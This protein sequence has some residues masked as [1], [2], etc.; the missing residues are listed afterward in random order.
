MDNP[1]KARAT[2]PTPFIAMSSPPLISSSTSSSSSPSPPRQ[3]PSP[4]INAPAGFPPPQQPHPTPLQ[5]VVL[6]PCAACKI[7]RR[8]CTDNCVLA[9]YFPPTE[10]LKFTT[11]HRVFG[12]SNIIKFLQELPETH[13]ADAVSSMVYEANARLRDPIYGCAGAICH[14]QKQVSD[15]QAQ[16][17]KSQAELLNLQAQYANLVALIYVEMS[18]RQSP[19]RLEEEEEKPNNSINQFVDTIGIFDDSVSN[20]TWEPLWT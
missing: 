5:P 7:L 10:P 3:S 14:L 6:S 8:R 20:S 19:G 16:L 17:A 4:T 1:S 15:L 11:A 12:A 18:D 9:P 13:R 2:F